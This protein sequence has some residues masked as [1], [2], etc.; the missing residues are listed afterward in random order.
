MERSYFPIACH[1]EL[2]LCVWK[3]SSSL[4]SFFFSLPTKKVA[5]KNKNVDMCP[6]LYQYA[7]MCA[8]C[9]FCSFCT[10]FRGLRLIWKWVDNSECGGE[11]QSANV[12]SK[13]WEDC[14]TRSQST[15]LSIASVAKQTHFM[16]WVA[17]IPVPIERSS[18]IHCKWVWWSF[19][20]IAKQ[21]QWQSPQ[22]RWIP[23][24]GCA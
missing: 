11:R 20:L 8:Q 23:Y 17:K 7:L 15:K 14:V 21:N 22:C 19:A 1:L 24:E 13:T 2:L 18:R 6:M 4:P 5:S 12:T 16:G 9:L 10:T 3:F